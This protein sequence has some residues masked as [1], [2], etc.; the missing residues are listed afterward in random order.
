MKSILSGTYRDHGFLG[1]NSAVVVDVETTGFSPEQDRVVSICALLVEDFDRA[2]KTKDISYKQYTT[3]VNPGIAIP[4]SA[5]RVHGITNRDV[6]NCD[7]FSDIATFLRDFIGDLPI[8]GHNIGFDKRFLDAEFKRAGVRGIFRKKSYC[9]MRRMKELHGYTGQGFVDF[10][11]VDACRKF[12]CAIERK[13]IHDP[14]EDAMMALQLAM[15]F[16]GIDNE[17]S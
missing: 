1:F 14:I 9:T 4:A 16:Y 11:L 3:K 5:T 8:I 6:A 12:G 15:V 13:S 17:I 10:K 7:S 2:V